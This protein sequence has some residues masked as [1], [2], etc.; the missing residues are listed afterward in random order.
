M[1]VDDNPYN[2][3]VMQIIIEEVKDR[4]TEVHTALNGEQAVN[5]ILR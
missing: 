1:V 2:L 5:M 4:E 3:F